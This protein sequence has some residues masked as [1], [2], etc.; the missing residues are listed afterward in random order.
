[1]IVWCGL[2]WFSHHISGTLFAQE[3]LFLINVIHKGTLEKFD[4]LETKLKSFL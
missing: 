1:M 3:N 4:T 2:A